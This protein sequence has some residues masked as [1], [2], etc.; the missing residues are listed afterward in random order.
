M[1]SLCY[2]EKVHKELNKII[3]R[4]HT[5]KEGTQNVITVH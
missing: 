2:T 1:L 5:K 3:R 4:K